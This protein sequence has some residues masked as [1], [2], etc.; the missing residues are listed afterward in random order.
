MPHI[1]YMQVIGIRRVHGGV[2]DRERLAPVGIA[3]DARVGANAVVTK[4]ATAGAVLTGIP[5]KARTR[6]PDDDT[7]A[8]LTVPDY[9]I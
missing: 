4:D 9:A 8:L 1:V 5:A 3:A 7:V 2:E 6:K